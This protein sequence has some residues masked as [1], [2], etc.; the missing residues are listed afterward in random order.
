MKPWQN[1]RQSFSKKIET[2]ETQ[3]PDE[4]LEKFLSF[5]QYQ[6]KFLLVNAPTKTIPRLDRL[7]TEIR[8]DEVD[9]AEA[10]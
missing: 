5:L 9:G 8:D 10:V 7:L 1:R 2:S 3:N 6:R 4:V